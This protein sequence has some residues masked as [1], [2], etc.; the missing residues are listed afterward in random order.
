MLA[1]LLWQEQRHVQSCCL[2]LPTFSGSG[3]EFKKNK[4]NRSTQQGSTLQ[5]MNILSFIKI[6]FHVLGP[7]I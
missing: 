3:L 1:L 6:G 7:E 5:T 4:Q 2:P